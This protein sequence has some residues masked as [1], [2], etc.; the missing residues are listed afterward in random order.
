MAKKSEWARVSDGLYRHR[1]GS[2]RIMRFAH[3]MLSWGEDASAYGMARAKAAPW[4][5][6]WSDWMNVEHR[7]R[8]ATLAAAKAAR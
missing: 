4:V 6:C 7:V 1:T 8:F 3:P 2:A 5:V